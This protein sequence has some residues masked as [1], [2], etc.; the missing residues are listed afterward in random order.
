MGADAAADGDKSLL[1]LFVAL[2]EE[3]VFAAVFIA[4]SL[5]SPFV[6]NDVSL[7]IVTL[8]G[9]FFSK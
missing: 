3:F 4:N 2:D 7:P 5:C 9:L 8:L 1:V 6:F